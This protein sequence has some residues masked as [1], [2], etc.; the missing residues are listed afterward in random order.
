MGAMAF[1]LPVIVGDSIGVRELIDDGCDGILVEAKKPQKLSMN[2]EWI[3]LNPDV[4]VRLG[5][6]ARNKIVTQFQST[7]SAKF[8]FDLIS[9]RK[10]DHEAN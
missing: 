6:A 4:A 9:T 2:I 1:E 3:A 5:Y 8:M 7:G 10:R